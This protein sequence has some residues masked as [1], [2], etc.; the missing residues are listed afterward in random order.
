MVSWDTVWEEAIEVAVNYVPKIVAA[1]IVWIV[2]VCIINKVLSFMKRKL[3]GKYHD[4][5]LTSFLLSLLG[6]TLKIMLFI[7]IID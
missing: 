3:K 7:I 2:G 4:A 1:I 5:T 6:M